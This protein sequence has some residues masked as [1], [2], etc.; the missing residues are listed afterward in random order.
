MHNSVAQNNHTFSE[1]FLLHENFAKYFLCRANYCKGVIL[2][3][4]T[5]RNKFFFLQGGAMNCGPPFAGPPPLPLGGSERKDQYNQLGGRPSNTKH[6]GAAAGG[7]HLLC[8]I[9]AGQLTAK[10]FARDRCFTNTCPG[11]VPVGA[12]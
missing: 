1:E 3:I 5:L 2:S 7:R 10:S 11:P 6:V 8:D 12:S 4:A 9:V